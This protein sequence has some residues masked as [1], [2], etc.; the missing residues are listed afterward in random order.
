MWGEV[1]SSEASGEVPAIAGNYTE[2]ETHR[3]RNCV[4]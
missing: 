1:F 4:I 3:L 2:Q